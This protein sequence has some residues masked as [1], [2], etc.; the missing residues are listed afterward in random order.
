MSHN[1]Q[2]ANS[3]LT[4]RTALSG[5]GLAAA[6]LGLSQVPVVTAQEAGSEM[7]S[8]PI[9]GAWLAMNP[10]NPP[11]ATP[12]IFAADGTVTIAPV[13]SYLDPDLGLTLQGG[14][15][16]VWEPTGERSIHFTLVQALSAVDGTYLGTFTTDGSP[17][18]SEDGQSFLDDGTQDYFNLRDASNTII[19]EAGGG[20]GAAAAT[21]P[22][23]RHPYGG[24]QPRLPG[25]NA[26]RRHSD[27]IGSPWE[28]EQRPK[29][30]HRIPLP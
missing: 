19:V 26:S 23:A 6:A 11:N 13:P 20:N 18:V 3:A 17:E 27:W 12:S 22:G 7:A 30:P 2:Y 21:P 8:H 4:R 28:G 25:G 24:G 9:V 5:V 15:I 10:G 14:G 16:G 1:T 29:K